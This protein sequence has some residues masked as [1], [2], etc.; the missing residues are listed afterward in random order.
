MLPAFLTSVHIWL[1]LTPALCSAQHTLSFLQSLQC[2]P[3]GD[4]L[5]FYTVCTCYVLGVHCGRLPLAPLR[6]SGWAVALGRAK[7]ELETEAEPCPSDS[8]SGA[9]FHLSEA[10][11]QLKF[12]I[13]FIF[14][15]VG[16][17]IQCLWR[18]GR[19][20]DLP[21]LEL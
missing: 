20:L 3:V 18:S 16:V 12:F 11:S 8:C 4:H 9:S 19:A 6:C 2:S 13:N 10:E 5:L 14:M 7:A 1:C 21:E 15:Y 17:C